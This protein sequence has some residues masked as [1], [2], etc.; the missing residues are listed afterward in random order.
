[1]SDDLPMGSPT[2]RY[3]TGLKD[4]KVAPTWDAHHYFIERRATITDEQWA[5]ILA[6]P[7]WT[8]HARQDLRAEQI[9]D[10][11]RRSIAQGFGTGPRT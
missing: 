3:I 11:C 10:W 9:C 1:M 4:L 6:M 2:P 5:E 8:D 7:D